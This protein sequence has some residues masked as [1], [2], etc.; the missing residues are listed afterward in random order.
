MLKTALLLRFP[1]TLCIV[2]TPGN[3]TADKT[4]LLA[5]KKDSFTQLLQWITQTD[6][7][8]VV[9]ERLLH[10]IKDIPHEVC[11]YFG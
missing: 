5:K 10:V 4:E 1:Q 9:R 7:P 11:V 6:T 3:T 2:Y 8:A